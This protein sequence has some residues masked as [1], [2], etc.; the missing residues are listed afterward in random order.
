[1]ISIGFAA[2]KIKDL[3]RSRK[4]GA[5]KTPKYGREGNVLKRFSD[6]TDNSALSDPASP[7]GSAVASDA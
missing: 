7:E 4:R 1:V 6:L 2:R 5:G 3:R